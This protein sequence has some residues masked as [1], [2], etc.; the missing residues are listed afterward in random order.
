ML[1]EYL[2]LCNCLLNLSCAF[3]PSSVEDLHEEHTHVENI[4]FP[5]YVALL[6]V[7]DVFHE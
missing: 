4:I 2:Y 5:C 1:L 7:I 6:D 3:V